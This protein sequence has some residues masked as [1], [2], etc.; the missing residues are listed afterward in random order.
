MEG[1]IELIGEE[2]SS[3]SELDS[4]KASFSILCFNERRKWLRSHSENS[5]TMF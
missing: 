2:T 5:D 1:F 4:A 3:S